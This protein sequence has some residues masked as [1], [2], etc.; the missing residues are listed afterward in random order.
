MYAAEHPIIACLSLL[1][2]PHRLSINTAIT[3]HKQIPWRKSQI[4]N[5]GLELA[6]VDM[7][8][9]QPKRLL[10]ILLSS[11]RSSYWFVVLIA[12]AIGVSTIGAS[13]AVDWVA[14]G[15]AR[16][17]YASDLLVGLTAAMFS[18]AALFQV[19][20]R[21]RELLRRMQIVEDV[22]LHVRNALSVITLSAALREDAELNIL[23]RDA[24]DRID[25]A[26]SDVLS[27]T[28]VA[29]DLRS[30]HPQWNSGWLRTPADKKQQTPRG[31]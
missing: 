18:G 3:L 28:A 10:T 25:W 1:A 30:T 11:W 6:L 16:R 22:N 26:L 13:L 7:R 12:L 5:E 20:A 4:L 29:G 19:Q 2:T 9:Q 8:H 24:S 23:I 15:I 17:V 27:K 14:H 21:R 31:E